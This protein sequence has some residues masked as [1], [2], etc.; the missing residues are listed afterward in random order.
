MSNQDSTHPM[1]EARQ[2]L[3]DGR[4]E[5]CFRNTKQY[6]LQH[7]YDRE[8]PLLLSELM[9]ALGQKELGGRLEKLAQS[10]AKNG[11]TFSMQTGT[12]NGSS[13]YVEDKPFNNAEDLFGAGH[14]LIDLRQYDLAAMLLRQ[15]AQIVPEEAAV[16]YELGFCLMSLGDFEEAIGQLER[17]NSKVDDFDTNLNLAV[18]YTL[19]RRLSQAQLKI[20]RIQALASTE[21]ERR[22]V[23]HRKI[24]MR[25]FEGLSSRSLL[26]ARDWLY[27]LYGSILLRP[28]TGIDL[29]SEN[30]ESVASMLLVLRGVLEGLRVELEVV[31]YYN[32]Q[33]KPFARMFSEIGLTKMDSYRG[34]DRPERALLMMSWASDL[35]GPHNSFITNSE[36]RILFCY[37]LPC[38]EPLPIAPE[39]I[40]CLGDKTPMPWDKNNQDETAVEAILKRA[41]DLDSDPEIIRTVQD[42]LDYYSD[43]REFLVLANPT[44]FPTRPEYTAELQW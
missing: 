27:I 39:V 32:S 6:W 40:G 35:I 12:M 17:A 25:R 26:S 11:Q 13:P 5:D 8:A 30:D 38:K 2:L 34:P 4:L 7:P 15:C 14:G 16:A 37:R 33:S 44:V 28:H 22:E 31:E 43:K 19:T 23:A 3:Q 1:S 42:A 18:C 41:L 10:L 21:E 24:V 36:S 29:K 9:N 20:D